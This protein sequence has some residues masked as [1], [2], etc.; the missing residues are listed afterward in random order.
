MQL[1]GVKISI[2]NP[3][4]YLFL[5]PSE[6]NYVEA[7]NVYSNFYL[8]DGTKIVS[9]KNLGYYEE[10]LEKCNFRRIHHSYII[11]MDKIYKFIR[12]ND[13]YVML[14]NKKILKVSRSY[15]DRLLQIFKA[16]VFIFD[17]ASAE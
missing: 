12:G 10:Q 7:D 2:P 17:T 6:I 14:E 3:E 15:K 11:N 13:S 4:G 16:G 9:S 8:N 5:N 1:K